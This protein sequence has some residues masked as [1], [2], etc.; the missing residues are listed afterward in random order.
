M[1]I[2]TAYKVAKKIRLLSDVETFTWH[3]L[4]HT[5]ATRVY[6]LLCD[7]EGGESMLKQMAG[8][9]TDTMLEHYAEEAIAERANAHLAEYI[10]AIFPKHHSREAFS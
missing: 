7:Q 5:W 10:D 3:K 9:R 6:K 8:W 2:S 1:S 4:R